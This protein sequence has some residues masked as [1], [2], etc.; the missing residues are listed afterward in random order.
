MSLQLCKLRGW[1][2]VARGVLVVTFAST[3]LAGC[4]DDGNPLVPSL[5]PLYTP[6]DIDFDPFLIGNWI[7]E[8]GEV[9]FR[10]EKCGDKQYCLTVTEKDGDKVVSGSFETLLGHLGGDQFLDFYPHELDDWGSFHSFHFLR[11]HTFARLEITSERL[12]LE[13][14][15]S[16]WLKKRLEDKSVD[17]PHESEDGSLLL[18]GTTQE[19]QD[20][21]YLYATEPE[22]FCNSLNLTRKKDEETQDEQ[23][24]S[25]T[26]H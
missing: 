11:A 16:D 20:L 26:D 3:F 22:A 8:N 21:V 13:F 7:D 14:F 6:A 1:P 5:R 17:T 4:E 12:K 9:G 25:S 10:F 24:D 23:H 18:T 15:R 19:I 2:A